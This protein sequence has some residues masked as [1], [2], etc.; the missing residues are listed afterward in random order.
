MT[1]IHVRR[2]LSI[3]TVT[4]PYDPE[5]VDLIKRV[6]PGSVRSWSPATKEWRIESGHYCDD[7]VR[8]AK[9]Y[10]HTVVDDGAKPQGGPRFKPSA[11]KVTPAL[12]VDWAAAL[13]DAL[14]GSV[15][16]KAYRALSRVLHSDVCDEC[17]DELMKS[18]NRAHDGATK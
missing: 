2:G 7:F 11:P 12:E 4:F 14:P 8:L 16:E 3:H 17:D 10:G 13:F 1:V 15:I 5:V 9:H 18:L 6:V